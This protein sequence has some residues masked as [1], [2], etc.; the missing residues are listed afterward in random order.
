MSLAELSKEEQDFDSFFEQAFNKGAGD[1]PAPKKVEEEDEGKEPD[2][3]DK[4]E[5]KVEDKAP[6][7]KQQDDASIAQLREQIAS[8]T[9]QRDEALH[10]WRSD[11]NRQSN[12]MREN[13]QLKEQVAG[14]TAKVKEL[15]TRSP[16]KPEAKD[17]SGL[18]DV[19]ESAPD[20]KAALER[21]IQQ[22]LEE[23]TRTLREKLDAAEQQLAEVGQTARDA[24]QRVEPLASREEQR[25]YEAVRAEL[26]K[27]FP[28]WR[29]DVAEIRVWINDQPDEIKAMFP[30][31]G[32]KDSST[33]LKLFYA[34]KGAAKPPAADA[35]TGAEDDPLRKAAGIA[36]RS[37]T[38][39][40]PNKD[41]FD[42]AFAEFSAKK[43]R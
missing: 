39:P 7:P 14:L 4:P 12:L 23:G 1:K 37:V 3:G 19:L 2:V 28:S 43:R 40:A 9:Q 35:G 27:L 24:A 20:L 15:E 38:R 30:G 13:N 22:A 18:S 42:G 21:R 32:L 41:D 16:A 5:P 25:S 6:E 34:D 29:Q 26:D 8:L 17:E 11:A 10:K 31:K 36:P 33:V